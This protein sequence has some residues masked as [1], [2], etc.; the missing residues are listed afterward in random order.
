MQHVQFVH[1]S[2]DGDLDCLEASVDEGTYLLALRYFSP[3]FTLHCISYTIYHILGFFFP[4]FWECLHE[5][6]YW[7]VSSAGH[8][9]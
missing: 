5:S 4:I 8:S 9:R 6:V 3:N 2:N 1:A 7:S